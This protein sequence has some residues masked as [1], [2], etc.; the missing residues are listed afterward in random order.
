MMAAA[1]PWSMQGNMVLEKYS[2][3]SFTGRIS[4]TFDRISA[5]GLLQRF[6][7]PRKQYP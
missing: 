2:K 4:Q 3:T 1:F 7:I 5:S 6:L